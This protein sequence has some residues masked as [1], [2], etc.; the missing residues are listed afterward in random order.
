MRP[1]RAAC[2]VA[3]RNLG[4]EDTF[5]F[6]FSAGASQLGMCIFGLPK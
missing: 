5:G 2:G 4:S 6:E 3:R 1:G